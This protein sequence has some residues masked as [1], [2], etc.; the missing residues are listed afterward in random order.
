MISS[1]P[2]LSR[3]GHRS[4][5]RNSR[6]A[7]R[8][9]GEIVRS[10]HRPRHNGP[11]AI[12]LERELRGVRRFH[13]FYKFEP[14]AHQLVRLACRDRVPSFANLAV[15]GPSVTRADAGSRSVI[16][17]FAVW[18]QF[19]PRIP[20]LP[21]AEFIDARKH[22]FRWRGYFCPARNDKFTR[23]SGDDDEQQEEDEREG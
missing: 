13:R 11:V 18:I 22:L 3:T 8:L 21:I 4:S 15:L 16:G 9:A 5:C 14:K 10:G 2:G 12:R 17:D 23:P 7:R 20:R 6:T 19:A 1:A